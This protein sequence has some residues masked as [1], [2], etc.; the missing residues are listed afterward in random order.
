MKIFFVTD[1]HGSSL[2]YLKAL[3][4]AKDLNIDLLII[5]G[6]LS[7]KEVIPVIEDNGEK[8]IVSGGSNCIQK[9]K[10]KNYPEFLRDSEDYGKYILELTFKQYVECLNDQL[11]ADGLILG[12]VIER[13]KNWVKEYNDEDRDYKL[14]LCPGNDDLIELDSALNGFRSK[15]ILIGINNIVNFKEF[16]ILNY[17]SVPFTPWATPREKTEEEIEIEIKRIIGGNI[18]RMG[19]CIFNF[20]CPPYNT[21]LDNA[22]LIDKQYKIV[23]KGGEIK[24]VH[25][26][27]KAILKLIKDS[28]PLL[29]LHGH[30]HESCAETFIQKTLCVNPGSEYAQGILRG[31][32]FDLSENCINKFHRLER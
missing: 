18:E 12:A 13:L 22:P 11:K 5:S 7:G 2:L 19:N 26:G 25:V 21:L 31:Y 24:K 10:I 29:S 16:Q 3:I 30:T 9:E 32:Y 28:Q 17:S 4:V 14:L 6:D 20:H 15:N 27:S 23:F 1:I 8:Y